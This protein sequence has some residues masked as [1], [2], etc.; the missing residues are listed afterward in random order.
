MNYKVSVVIPV[1]NVE[2]YIRQCIDSVL[3]Q[4]LKDIEVI[5]VDD[6]STDSCPQIL[7]EYG[8]MDSRVRV[9]HKPNSGYGHSMNVGMD[10]AR[11][12]YFAIVESDDV[13]LPR[14]YES[15][16]HIAKKRDVDVIK[17]NFFKFVIHDGSIV[18][19]LNKCANEQSMYGRVIRPS[20]DYRLTLCEAPLY[21]WTGLYRREFLYE[22]NI[23]HNETP[24]ASYQDNG[25]WFQTIAMADTLYFHDEAF[26]MLRR[27]N[28]NSSI[29]NKKKVFCIRD[30]YEFIL[31]YL[32]A[33]FDQIPDDLLQCYWRARFTAYYHSF[34]RIGNEYKADFMK[35]FSDVFRYASE[36]IGL[37]E[38][39]YTTH[40]WYLLNE[41]IHNSDEHV[42][43]KKKTVNL[44]NR[45]IWKIKEIGILGAFRAALGYAKRK[46][47]FLLQT[48]KDR[49]TKHQLEL[50]R[51]ELQSTKTELI[52]KTNDLYNE[53]LWANMYFHKTSKSTWL[54][55]D[56]RVSG[57]ETSGY[58]INT[59]LVS[60]LETVK[61][62]KIL[63]F[64]EGI[65]HRIVHQYALANEVEMITVQNHRE[66]A[67]LFRNHE[68]D[69]NFI[70]IDEYFGMTAKSMPHMV[71][72]DSIEKL[73]NSKESF[74]LIQGDAS[75]GEDEELS[76]SRALTN[77]GVSFR[78][79][80]YRGLTGVRVW[81]SDNL[82]IV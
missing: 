38:E 77:N 16:Y 24:G 19:E 58:V 7:D 71:I 57:D 31:N 12:E 47:F 8:K 61:P 82:D 14:M 11:G 40:G 20:D 72:F 69:M 6:G 9:I 32:T 13:I 59:V 29:H 67:E 46:A 49:S 3:N 17:S 54:D 70:I 22:N 36:N 73:I 18:K 25:F 33:H 65:S 35:H 78:T 42:K 53:L 28:P 41:V 62:P 63:V 50:V 81:F 10:A 34:E 26:Y 39:Y 5:L 51:E 79:R 2:K 1:Y 15:L 48:Y 80:L 75:I 66:E 43:S 4:T 21:T 52:E 64:G 27:D 37:N 76:I 74:V 23:R 68:R 55:Y 60:F 30:E 56:L 44:K 45:L